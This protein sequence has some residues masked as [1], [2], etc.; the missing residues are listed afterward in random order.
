VLPALVGI[1]AIGMLAA[2]QAQQPDARTV[3]AESQSIHTANG[4]E[5]REAVKIGGIEQWITVRGKDRNNPLLLFVHGGPGDAMM[6]VSW[7][8]QRP[9]ED[10]FTVVEWD[11]RGAGKTYA[12]NDWTKMKPTLK[13]ERFVD[14]AEEL[15]QYLRTKYHK[16][17]IVLLCLSWGTVIGTEL[18]QRHPDWFSVYVGTGQVVDMRES[19]RMGYEAILKEARA[20]NNA[21]A[22]KK[23]EALAPYPGASGPMDFNKTMKERKWLVHYGGYTWRNTN[24]HFGDILRLSP[25]YTDTEVKGYELGDAE[26]PRVMWAEMSEIKFWKQNVFRCPV[27]LFEGSHD[28]NVSHEL[29]ARWFATLHAP[30]KKMVWFPNSSHMVMMEEPGRMFSHLMTDVRPLAMRA[31]QATPQ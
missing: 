18:A 2:L 10:Y 17:K 1:S 15:V 20:E 21:Q 24:D 11:Q 26:S 16:R 28:L 23:L 25:D 3:I 22:V 4:V 14:D 12:A 19:E 9:W 30:E 31:E 13:V 7:S 29:A 6:G 8:F 27:V 5:V